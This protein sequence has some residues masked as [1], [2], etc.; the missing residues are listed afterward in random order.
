MCVYSNKRACFILIELS[1]V[2]VISKQYTRQVL[3][4][5][6]IINLSFTS[7]MITIQVIW[8]A[9]VMLLIV[10]KHFFFGLRCY[11]SNDVF[12]VQIS[13][14]IPSQ[15]YYKFIIKKTRKTLDAMPKLRCMIIRKNSKK[16]LDI[17][18][19]MYCVC[20]CV[21]CFYHETID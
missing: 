17:R 9:L 4:K 5:I 15:T 2:Y 6:R 1:Q 12:V 19:S 10:G 3:M 20:S 7:R 11:M 8:I 21:T 14:L 13:H 16:G 18:R